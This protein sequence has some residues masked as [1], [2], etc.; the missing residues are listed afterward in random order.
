V[1]SDISLQVYPRKHELVLRLPVPYLT[2]V[3]QPFPRLLLILSLNTVPAFAR[4]LSRAEKSFTLHDLP[5]IRSISPSEGRQKDVAKI[6]ITADNISFAV[7][8]L[9]CNI[10]SLN[11]APQFAAVVDAKFRP[12]HS[13]VRN[14]VFTC[15]MPA[16]PAGLVL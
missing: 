13:C 3:Y 9:K 7:G 1:K 10:R 8:F 14:C 12:Q 4:S 15:L 2:S 11:P 6:E 5:V 16:Q